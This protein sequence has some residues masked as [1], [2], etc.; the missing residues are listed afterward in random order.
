LTTDPPIIPLRIDSDLAGAEGDVLFALQALHSARG[1]TC[2]VLYS[3]SSISVRSG[4]GPV[5]SMLTS[6]Y[7][8]VFA[9]R[10]LGTGPRVSNDGGEDRIADCVRGWEFKSR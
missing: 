8:P 2:T 9:G 1:A 6:S 10:S 3:Q 7:T 4:V 5:T